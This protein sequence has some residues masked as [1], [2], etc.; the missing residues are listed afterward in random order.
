M[1]KALIEP[2]LDPPQVVST[3]L[4]EAGEGDYDFVAEI[5]NPH[6]SFGA[7]EVTYELILFNV[8]DDEL[9]Q[10]SGTF[11][12]L[13]AQTKFLILPFLTTEKNVSRIE[14]NITSARWQKIDSLE[15][16]NL[17]V[18]R[19]VFVPSTSSSILEAVIFNDSDFDFDTI[20]VD[21]ILRNS[22]GEIIA[23]NKSEINT[24]QARSE[25]GFRVTWPLFQNSNFIK[26]YGSEVEKFQDYKPR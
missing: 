15:G 24:F 1:K 10:R 12:I 17:I 7:S 25:R 4:L 8:G 16:L 26:R 2:D 18:R 23:V 20:S 9:L 19:E 22:R 3:K 5:K 6:A 14:F 13:P 21:V 11:Y